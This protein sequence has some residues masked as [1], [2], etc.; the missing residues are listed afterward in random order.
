M[1]LTNYSVN[2][3][4]EEYVRCDNP[5][6]ENYGNKW[7]MSAMLR[8]LTREGK[9]TFGMMMQ[10]EELIIKTILSVERFMIRHY[11]IFI[12]LIDFFIF[13]PL[14]SASRVF[15]P[16]RGNCFGTF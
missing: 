7:S 10:I 12:K 2:K 1:H 6:V 8:H 3:K 11:I 14:S 5:S 9:D 15:V 13:S 16:F 4:N